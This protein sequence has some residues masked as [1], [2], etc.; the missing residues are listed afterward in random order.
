[1]KLDIK[2]VTTI[3]A[4]ILALAGIF[5]STGKLSA[6]VDALTVA[7]EKIHET[8]EEHTTGISQLDKDLGLNDLADIHTQKEVSELQD[9]VK[10]LAQLNKKIE[11]LLQKKDG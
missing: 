11:L 9:T 6:S 10:L 8:M 1:M 3:I 5:H 2:T 4:C 7:V